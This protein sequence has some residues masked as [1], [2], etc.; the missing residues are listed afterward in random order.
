MKW[1]RTGRSSPGSPRSSG[2]R[3]LVPF[4]ANK[5]GAAEKT[6]ERKHVHAVPQKAKYEIKYP[7]VDGYTQAIR[8]RVTVDWES[9]ALRCSTR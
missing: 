3:D 1:G 4:K 2:C 9:V 7:R 5:Q 6:E 8:N